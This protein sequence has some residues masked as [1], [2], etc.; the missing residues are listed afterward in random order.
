MGRYHL[1]RLAD[2]A[3]ERHGDYES[4]FF[5][6]RWYR[7]GDL[8]ER[9]RRLSRGLVELGIAPGDRVV[10]VMANCPEV[11]IA[12]HALWRAGAVITPAVFLLPPEEIRLILQDA[13]ARAVITTPEFLPAVR[14]A[15]SGVESVKWIVSAGPEE[16]GVLSL[17]SLE[18]APPGGIVDRED[19]DLAALMYT[20]GTTGRAKGVMLSHE[21][22]WRVGEAAQRAAHIDG[23]TR[24]LAALPLSHGYGLVVSV[25]A[26]HVPERGQ[27][28]LM[29]WFEPQAWLELAAEHRMQRA[30]VVPTM[31]QLLLGLPLEDHDLSSLRVI[32]C[33]ASPLPPEVAREF[34]RRVP[35]AEVLEGY[36][37]TESGAIMTVNPPGRRKLG[38]VGLPLPGYE[39]AVFG[40]DD[41]PVAPEE[42]GE[43]ASRGP[44]M[45]AG[46]WRSPGETERALR[47]GW[48]R[49]GDLGRLDQDGYLWIVDRKKDLI[50]RSGVNVFP[51]DV[52]DALVEHPGVQAAGV[53]GRPD[54][55]R[56]EEVV[57]FVS[58]HSGQNV[59]R[60][61]LVEWSKRR[62]SREAYPRDVRIVGAVPLTPIGKVDRKA[63]RALL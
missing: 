29:R 30:V 51:R 20:G 62:L 44:G 57:A 16:D 24:T 48:L 52:E 28:V 11:P 39:V 41:R 59:T 32:T 7:S 45:M 17:S 55:V 31:L 18:E 33:G 42:V 9:V 46:Y 22:L 34:E 3:F 37:L 50:I 49:T 14:S 56:G 36:G 61:E 53:V 25:A 38:S 35:G 1:A 10:V 60:E 6:G 4:L 23:V 13:E 54:P 21:A 2:A 5:E 63:L 8:Q 27:A 40:D 26:L 12:Y 58:L 15:A 19:G 47:G 43:V